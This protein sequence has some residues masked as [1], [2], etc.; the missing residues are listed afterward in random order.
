MPA[1]SGAAAAAA[2]YLAGV[3]RDARVLALPE[4]HV[5][6]LLDSLGWVYLAGGRPLFPVRCKSSFIGYRAAMRLPSDAD[7]STEIALLQ[8]PPNLVHRLALYGFWRPAGLPTPL[9]AGARGWAS[10]HEWVEVIRL[11]PTWNVGEGGGFGAWFELSKGTGVA[12]NVGRTL[13]AANRSELAA[14]LEL[15]LTEI[16]SKPNSG[17]VH[18]WK[19]EATW[20][21]DPS[22]APA[23][24][25]G[26]GADDEAALRRRYFDNYPWRLEGRVNLCQVQGKAFHS[27]TT[28]ALFS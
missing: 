24:Y 3:Y 4:A 15:N 20:T 13:R 22:T 5:R 25:S 18:L 14:K 21:A 1:A 8:K 28:H 10:D 7:G 23:L 19:R 17:H 16:F 11:R 2:S 12:L 26:L 27:H 9:H 6:R